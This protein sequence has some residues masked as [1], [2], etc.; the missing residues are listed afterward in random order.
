MH[1][2]TWFLVATGSLVALACKRETAT[3]VDGPSASASATA[4]AA[5]EPVVEAHA[6]DPPL[7]TVRAF[8]NAIALSDRTRALGY[9]LRRDRELARDF[10]QRYDPEL[11]RRPLAVLS[12]RNAAGRVE[13]DVR[14][15]PEHLTYFLELEDGVWRLDQTAARQAAFDSLRAHL[16]DAGHSDAEVELG[17]DLARRLSRK[18]GGV[19]PE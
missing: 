10:A 1:A 11:A 18:D 14:E 4:S 6:G 3:T 7:T 9:F 17:I 19:D 8:R 16:R 13:I 5:S 15:G 12:T 2:S